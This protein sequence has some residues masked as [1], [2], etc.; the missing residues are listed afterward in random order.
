MDRSIEHLPHLLLLCRLDRLA[1]EAVAT[2]QPM[3]QQ[4]GLAHA[5]ASEDDEQA[6]GAR[7]G[8][9]LLQFGGAID[10]A[11]IHGAMMLR[12]IMFVKHHLRAALRPGG[13]PVRLGPD[14]IPVASGVSVGGGSQ[15]IEY[16]EPQILPHLLFSI[17]S[18]R[19]RRGP[20]SA[21]EYGWCSEQVPSSRWFSW[22]R[23]RSDSF[24]SRRPTRTI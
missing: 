4:P 16:I 23:S 6:T 7:Q 3:G 5:P 21:A 18:A 2:L 24:T 14:V 15:S 11:Q 1:V 20:R 10:E 8:V 12:D 19:R 22:F 17:E 13:N 9:E